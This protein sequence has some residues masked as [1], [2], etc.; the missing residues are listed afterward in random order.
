MSSWTI[1]IF[2]DPVLCDEGLMY[3]KRSFCTMVVVIYRRVNSALYDSPVIN[4]IVV[5]GVCNNIPVYFL[6]VAL[7]GRHMFL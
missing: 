4:P 5:D 7:L 2:I 1:R 3:V 6:S